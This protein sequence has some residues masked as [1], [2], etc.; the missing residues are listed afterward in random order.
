MHGNLD[1]PELLPKNPALK[2]LLDSLPMPK[3]IF[4]NADRVHADVC[5]EQIG[6]KDC[7]Q[8]IISFD[9]IYETVNVKAQVDWK[10]DL[11]CKPDLRSFEY[12]LKRSNAEAETTMFLDDSAANIKGAKDAGLKTVLVGRSEK[13]EGADH[14]ISNFLE[15]KDAAPYLW[16]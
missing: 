8:D 4:T 16:K 11:F 5:L 15:L 3:F 9:C 10:K 2:D 12:A 7:F 14:A 6:I 1:Y 13:C